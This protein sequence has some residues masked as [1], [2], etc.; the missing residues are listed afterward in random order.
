MDVMTYSEVQV[1]RVRRVLSDRPGLTEREMFGVFAFLMHGNM[2]A[3]VLGE[4][5]MLRLGVRAAAALRHEPGVKP[6]ESSGRRP[7]AG[8]LLVA[9]AG[10]K[11]EA[12][13]RTW[14]GRAVVY[15]SSLPRKKGKGV[16]P[17]RRRRGGR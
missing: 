10:Y 12:A 14:V 9:P 8:W 11:S 1:A 7:M 4:E 15:A 5:L 13:L 6:F 16:H 3:G 2:F 17:S